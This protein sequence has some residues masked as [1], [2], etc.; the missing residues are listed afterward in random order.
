[1]TKLYN[2]RLVS[3]RRNPHFEDGLIVLDRDGEVRPFDSCLYNHN[4]P[5]FL[6]KTQPKWT[7]GFIGDIIDQET[8]EIEE[9]VVYTTNDN[10]SATKRKKKAIKKFSSH[11]EP[12]YQQR[13]VS[14]LLLTITRANCA[15]T[16]IRDFLHQYYKRFKRREIEVLGY[17]WVSEVS[18]NIHWH[19]HIVLAIPRVKWK[20]IPNWIKPTG[21]WGQ[22]TQVEFVKK[23]VAGYLGKYIGKDNIGRLQGY[24]GYGVSRKFHDIPQDNR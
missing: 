5:S 18:K 9:N 21:I 16:D 13:Q 17:L 8:G 6:V 1:M 19:Y 4:E 15:N 24:R 3:M 11:F 12:L 20:S 7:Q 23:S 14:V 22:R 10:E 2:F